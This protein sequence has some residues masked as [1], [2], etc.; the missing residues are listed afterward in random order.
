MVSRVDEKLQ[1]RFEE[2]TKMTFESQ[3]KLWL[4]LFWEKGAKD[5]AENVWNWVN[6]MTS[7]HKQG[8]RGCDLDEFEAH[9]FIESLGET[10]TVIALRERLRE[11]DVNS[12]KKMCLVEYLLFKFGAEKITH[13]CTATVGDQSKIDAAKKLVE[14]CQAKLQLALTAKS[15][16]EKAEADNKAALQ[17]LQKQQDEFNNKVAALEA[18]SEG[19][20]VKANTAKAEL[21]KLKSEDP[22]PLSR[23]KINQ[24][25]TVRKAEK[26][27]KA[28]S[29]AYEAAEKAFA[30]A[31]REMELIRNQP[32]AAYGS[33]WFMER[34]IKEAKK[35]MPKSKQ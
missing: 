7:Q 31:D 22:L 18:A 2:I 8:K 10:L 26:A 17:E 9:K 28:A 20:G 3:G 15:A 5:E 13:L 27:A 19:S 14:D 4:D 21:F 24:E 16:A 30:D 33:I 29:E 11:I 12:D 34:D 32:G 6:K 35:F 23:A 25:A 1:K